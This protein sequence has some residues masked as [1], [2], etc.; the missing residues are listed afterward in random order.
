MATS[1]AQQGRFSYWDAM[2]LA[3]AEEAG[4]TLVLSEDTGDGARLGN[5]VIR[6]PF[7]GSDLSDA[8][9]RVLGL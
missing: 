8:A 9:K 7:A 3:C 5:V 1:A 4:C 6:N 2:L